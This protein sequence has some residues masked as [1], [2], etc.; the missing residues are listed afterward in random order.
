M[1]DYDAVTLYDAC[2]D[3]MDMIGTSL[4][5]DASSSRPRSSFD[6]FGTSMLEFNGDGLVSTDI[7]HDTISV[8][9]RPTLWTPPLCFDAMSGFVTPP[10]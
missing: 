4:I 3:T 2:T 7:A 9:E 8:R 6:V 10:L 1:V 5:L